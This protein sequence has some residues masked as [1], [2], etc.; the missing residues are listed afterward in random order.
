ML[1]IKIKI[2][3]IHK[4]KEKLNKIIRIDLSILALIFLYKIIILIY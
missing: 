1:E 4:E 2:N 3:I